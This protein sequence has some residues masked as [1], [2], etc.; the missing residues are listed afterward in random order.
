LVALSVGLA[1]I[2]WFV[3]FRTPRAGAASGSPGTELVVHA[4]PLPSKP[5]ILA[6]HRTEVPVQAGSP[7]GVKGLV[8]ESEVPRKE[9]RVAGILAR[10]RALAKD[11]S[12]YHRQAL[13]L[14]DELSRA[15][16]DEPAQDSNPSPPPA[17]EE[18]LVSVV[19]EPSESAL[20][21]GAVFL[22]LAT[23]LS[24]SE[25]WRTFENWTL[26]DPE[27]PLELVRTAALAASR[28]G[29]PSPCNA[30]L[31]LK[32]L[33]A[34]PISGSTPM[35]GFYLLALDR[36]APAGACV[37]LRQWLDTDDP[38]RRLFRPST[39]PPPAD[40]DLSAA[41]DYFVTVEVLFC[42]WGQQSLVDSEVES[43][44]VAEALID[45]AG[46]QDGTFERVRAALFLIYSLS[47]CSARFD[48][49][50]TR[51][52]AS[53]EKAVAGLAT[54]MQRM[55]VGGIGNALVEEIEN[56][57]YS[58]ASKDVGKLVLILSDVG[59]NLGSAGQAAKEHETALD[60]LEW[61]AAD[62]Y[63]DGRARSMALTA[64]VKSGSWEVVRR[65]T[66]AALLQLDD[67]TLGAVALT[68]LVT[69]SGKSPERRAEVVLLL[70]EIHEKGVSPGLLSSMD[71]YLME[72][73]P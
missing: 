47:S 31:S 73:G 60:Y 44:V 67:D 71:A 20:V 32:R 10:L 17:H 70:R 3:H 9:D 57:R 23:R 8:G 13:P 15:C 29:T 66:R 54:V 42:V 25:F 36:I 55:A 43:A 39:A 65:A 40:L 63:V 41:A 2:G 34:L 19:E 1:T 27:V 56:L 28:R 52:A 22:A 50:G 14:I 49:A 11:P 58:H 62:P 4:A 16:A 30:E 69:E 12:T 64:I 51:A 45:G 53:R 72:L 18:L 37:S 21:R 7:P 26:G 48:N 6:A 38:R 61:L 5:P 68:S 24:E 59:Q 46:Q 33:A 35:P